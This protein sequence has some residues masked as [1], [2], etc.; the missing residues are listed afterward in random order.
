VIFLLSLFVVILPTAD[1]KFRNKL[2]QQ[3]TT[4]TKACADKTAMDVGKRSCGKA[5]RPILALLICQHHHA[6][7][8]FLFE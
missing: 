7:S 2:L 5:K 1:E 3:A 8:L 6:I 4:P